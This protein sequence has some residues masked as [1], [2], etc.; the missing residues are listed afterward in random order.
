MGDGSQKLGNLEHTTQLEGS[1]PGEGVFSNSDLTLFQATGLSES[2]LKLS[3][4]E[5]DSQP[6]LLT[7]G[8]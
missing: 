3:S 7:L 8:G 1:S 5:S 6:V 2:S 4:S